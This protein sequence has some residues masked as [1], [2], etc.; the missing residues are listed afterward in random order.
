[1]RVEA[2][3]SRT[4]GSLQSLHVKRA[5]NRDY[6]VFGTIEGINAC[7]RV[8]DMKVLAE[9]VGTD[10]ADASESASEMRRVFVAGRESDLHDPYVPL[11]QKFAGYLVARFID[12]A[13]V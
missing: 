5:R 1:M 2:A 13:C 3:Y 12:E 10:A 7:L 4:P 11:D 8:Q 6:P 9:L